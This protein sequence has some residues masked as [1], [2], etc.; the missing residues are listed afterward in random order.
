VTLAFF[1]PLFAAFVSPTSVSDVRVRFV[2]AV[3]SQGS[4]E[5]CRDNED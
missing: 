5:H 3:E 4:G 2:D 1:E